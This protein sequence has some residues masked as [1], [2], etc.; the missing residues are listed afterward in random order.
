MHSTLDFWHKP[1]MKE[2][3]FIINIL[4]MKEVI[5]TEEFLIII[6]NLN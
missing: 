2:N 6:K 1:A 3:A 5:K 4:T